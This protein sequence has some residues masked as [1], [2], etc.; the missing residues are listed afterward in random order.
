MAV[1][2][3][4]YMIFREILR[5]TNTSRRLEVK[6]RVD[7]L[8]KYADSEFH[9]RFRLSKL[10]VH[11][12]LTDICQTVH[13]P[14]FC[15][16]KRSVYCENHGKSLQLWIKLQWRRSGTTALACAFQ[17][18]P[19]T[20]GGYSLTPTHVRTCVYR[21]AVFSVRVLKDE[22]VVVIA[23]QRPDCAEEEVCT[24]SR[25]R[26]SLCFLLLLC[27]YLFAVCFSSWITSIYCHWPCLV[28]P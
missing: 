16:I 11:H 7:L 3:D 15:N 14:S 8:R 25:V 2:A 10:T 4:S 12:L 20:L 5:L 19:A 23:E 24:C 18:Q 1:R 28:A 22:R 17:P 21:I 26:L 6:E 9:A 27:L 13:L